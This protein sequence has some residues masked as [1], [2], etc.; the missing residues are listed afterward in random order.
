M[1][2]SEKSIM[3]RM[4]KGKLKFFDHQQDLITALIGV[5]LSDLKVGD[6]SPWNRSVN[7]VVKSWH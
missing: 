2:L 7:R 3:L 6:L 4:W 5:S 1:Q